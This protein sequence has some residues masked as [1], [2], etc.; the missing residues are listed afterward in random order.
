MT[1]KCVPRDSIGTAGK[2]KGH[3]KWNTQVGIATQ[4][5]SLDSYHILATSEVVRTS[6][7]YWFI[8]DYDPDQTVTL[9]Y[10]L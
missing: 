10:Y 7:C 5:S 6:S 3:R 4:I 1:A 8:Q 2:R 9:A